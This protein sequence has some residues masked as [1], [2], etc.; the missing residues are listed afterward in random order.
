MLEMLG[1]NL[2]FTNSLFSKVL[3]HKIIFELFKISLWFA[4]NVWSVYWLIWNAKNK[5]DKNW[6][7]ISCKNNVQLLK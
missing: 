1:L 6:N 4:I 2:T 7:R 3:F 5:F